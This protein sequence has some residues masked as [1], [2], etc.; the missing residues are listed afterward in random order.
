MKIKDIPWYDRPGFRLTREGAE[1]LSN[2]ELLSILFWAN[3]KEDNV[4]ELSNKILKKYNLNK[5]DEV[6]YNELVNLVCDNKKAEY[7]DFV[8]VMK[9]LSLIELSKRYGKLVKGGYNKKPINSAKDVYDML[10]D[11]MINYKKEVLK[12]ILLDTKNVPISVKDVSVGTLNSSLAHPR[13]IFKEAIKE[14]AYS[15]ILVH[16]H[17][18]GNCEPSNE[19]LEI[20]KVLM[21]AG[22]HLGIKVLDHVI[23]G[24]DKY[25]NYKENNK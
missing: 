14:S 22:E 4:L 8:K 10:V 23:I 15:I 1:K 3:D 6:G 9:L 12:V 21:K 25:W 18:S 2:P 11:E 24:K 17:P 5:I 7:K 20:T 16:N 13:E 19:D